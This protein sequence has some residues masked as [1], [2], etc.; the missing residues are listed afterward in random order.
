MYKSERVSVSPKKNH[1]D[2]QINDV[3]KGGGRSIYKNKKRVFGAYLVVCL[4]YRNLERDDV[5]LVFIIWACTG[6]V[7]SKN[8]PS[9]SMYR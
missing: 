2:F 5:K 4:I 7:M 3:D 9:K 8:S 6:L 1:I